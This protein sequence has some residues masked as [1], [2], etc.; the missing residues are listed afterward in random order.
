MDYLYEAMDRAKESIRAYYDDKGDE[1]FQKQLLLWKVIDERWN[2]TLHHPIHAAGIYLNPAF[3]YPCGFVFDAKIVDGFLTYVQR[4]VRSPAE[5][6]EIFK[7]METYGMAGG[8]FGFEMAVTDRTTKMPEYP[9]YKN[10]PF[11]SSAK[12]VAPQDA[13]ATRVYLKNTQEEAQ[14]RLNDM[15]YVYY[16]LR[17]WVRQLERIPDMEAISLNGIDTTAAWRV[18]A[19]RPLMESASNWLEQ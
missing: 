15:V 1:G 2:N 19:E 17:L 7:E 5:R 8:T 13:S 6:T 16:N 10:L 14:Q 12:H 11:E 18:E 4:M 3:S 9:I